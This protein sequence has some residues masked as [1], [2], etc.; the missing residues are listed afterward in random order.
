VNEP[1]APGAPAPAE[2]G[3]R[4]PYRKGLPVLAGALAGLMLRLLFWGKP[5]E[6]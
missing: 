2:S 1:A 3:E 4:L 5:G 6:P